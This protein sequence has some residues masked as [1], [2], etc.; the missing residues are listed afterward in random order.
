MSCDGVALTS[1]KFCKQSI[2]HGKVPM[3][4][5]GSVLRTR[6]QLKKEG[7]LRSELLESSSLRNPDNFNSSLDPDGCLVQIK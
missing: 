1:L 5:L 4:F 6:G 2:G 7:L 3:F